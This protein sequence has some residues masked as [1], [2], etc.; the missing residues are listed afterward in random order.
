MCNY[1]D[2]QN[3]TYTT[4]IAYPQQYKLYGFKTRIKANHFK[5]YFRLRPYAL[6]AFYQIWQGYT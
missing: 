2:F 5:L 6:G 3:A 1:D 4:F